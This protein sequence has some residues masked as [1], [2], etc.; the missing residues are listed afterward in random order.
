[1]VVAIILI[2]ILGYLCIALENFLKIN[3][4][5]I[6]L[7]TGVLCWTL[8]IIFSNEKDRYRNTQI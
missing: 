8:Y 6:A 3:K 2:F 5:A 7:V 4:A 1:M